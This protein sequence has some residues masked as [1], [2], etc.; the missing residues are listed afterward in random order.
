MHRA[1][2]AGVLVLGSCGLCEAQTTTAPRKSTFAETRVMPGTNGV[3]GSTVIVPSRSPFAGAGNVYIF[4]N[5]GQYGGYPGAYY[6][7][8]TFNAFTGGTVVPGMTTPTLPGM[9]PMQGIPYYNL[10]VSPRM[11]FLP[12]APVVGA[13]PVV[14]PPQVQSPD[15]GDQNL[16]VP[17]NPDNFG[18]AKK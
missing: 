15:A 12:P 9:N 8:T 5:F 11:P 1:I 7:P 13:N 10:N 4:N 3:P 6:P 2:A 16:V 14:P 18:G 17:F